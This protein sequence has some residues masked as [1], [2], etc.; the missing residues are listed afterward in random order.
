MKDCCRPIY[1]LLFTMVVSVCLSCRN[2]ATIN[3]SPVNIIFLM[4]DDQRAD[5]F[6]FMG[7]EH[8]MTPHLDTLAREGIVFENAYHVSP[9]CMP[10]RTSV[11]TG[12]YLGT[13]GSGFDRPTNYILTEEEFQRSYPVLLRDAGYFTG[14]I[15]KFGFAVADSSKVKNKNYQNQSKYMPAQQFDVWN[16]FPGQGSYQPRDGQFNGYENKWNADHLTAFMGYQ[17]IDFLQKAKNAGQPFC[18]SI[19]F[20]A[21]HAPFRPAPNFR[22]SYDA[23]MIPRMDDDTPEYYALLP[24]VVKSKSRNAQWYFGRTRDYYGKEVAYREDWHIEQ[25]SIYQSFIKNYYA[26]IS[27]IDNTVGRIRAALTSMGLDKNTIIV[28]TSDN[29]FFAGSRQLMGKALLYEAS[30]RAPMIVYHPAYSQNQDTRWEDGLISH[31]DIAPTILNM[32]GLVVPEH[33]PGSSFLPIIDD[34]KESIHEAVYGENNYDNNYPVIS[35]VD[36]PDTYQSIRSRFVRTSEYKLIRYHENRPVTEE[37]Y[38]V[39]EDTT[40]MNNLIDDPAYAR[41]VSTM[42]ALLDDFESKYIKF[43]N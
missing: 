25:D 43:R 36:S 3:D 10:S 31:V 14:F 6:G 23:A 30:A 22:R 9:I 35:E 1:F 21:P 2:R 15:G 13:H 28:Y 16:G 34:E 42:R 39:D 27:G 11:M 37:L 4:A 38:K 40:E 8:V 41:T 7:N 29:G 26:L 19:S 12:Q 32:A 18:L 24:E 5:A 20:K 33:Y 17:A